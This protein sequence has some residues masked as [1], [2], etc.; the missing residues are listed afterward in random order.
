MA[1]K[2]TLSGLDVVI[3]GLE[4]APL[5]IREAAFQG[6]LLA[7]NLAFEACKQVISADDHSLRELA[8]MGHPYGYTH[9]QIIHDPDVTVHIQSGDYVSHLRRDTPRGSFGAIIAGQVYNDSDLDRYIQE[10]TSRMRK[11]PWMQWVSDHFGQE[12]ADVIEAK[13]TE[14]VQKLAA[15]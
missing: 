6:V 4:Q 9:A 12:M 1:L 5:D 15:A 2:V 13:I 11:R 10:G 7:L 14:A 8:L 3:G